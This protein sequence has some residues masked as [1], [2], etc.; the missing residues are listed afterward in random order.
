LGGA[1]VIASVSFGLWQSWWQA[2]LWLVA[3]FTA[4]VSAPNAKQ[5]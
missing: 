1:V 5:Q 3:I 2:S 4:A